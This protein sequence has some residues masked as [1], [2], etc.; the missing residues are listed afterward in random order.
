MASAKWHTLNGMLLD[1]CHVN[2]HLGSNVD[3]GV[4]YGVVGGLVITLDRCLKSHSLC[5]NS[6]ALT[7]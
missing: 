5:P 3:G 4:S 6:V 7:G 1:H 2:V